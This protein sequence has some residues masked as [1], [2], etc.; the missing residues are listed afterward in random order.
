[1][2]HLPIGSWRSSHCRSKDGAANVLESLRIRNLGVIVDATLDMGRGLTVLTGETGAGKT[3]VLTAL[4]AVLGQKA[5]PGLIRFGVDRADVEA[6]WVV[7]AE[8]FAH[9][10]ERL[11]EIDAQLDVVA[12]GSVLI[13]NRSIAAQ[14]RSKTTVGGRSVASATL[15]EVIEPLVAVHGQADQWRLLRA[16]EQRTILDTFGGIDIAAYRQVYRTW[17]D[18]TS[19]LEQFDHD[20]QDA[21]AHVAVLRS[22]LAAIEAV[23]PEV[24]EDE[25]LDR[26]SNVLGHAVSI[27]QDADEI[28]LALDAQGEADHDAGEA[29]DRALRAADRI[30]AVDAGI[31]G[32][33]EL[34]SQSQVLIHEAAAALG[35]YV[36]EIDVD[37]GRL[38]EVE[39]RRR[40]LNDLKRRFGPSLADVLTWR[41][42]AQTTLTEIADPA[43][44]RAALQS[45]IEQ[46]ATAL[47]AQA[48][49]VTA[50]RSTA[51]EQLGSQVTGELQALAMAGNAL[52]VE[53]LPLPGG[54]GDFGAETVVF[55]L[56]TQAGGPPRPLAKGASGGELARVMLAIEV[57]V[58]GST[59][60]PTFVF[61]EVDAGVGGRA[62]IE[63]GRRLAALGRTAQVLVVTHLPQVAA[64][65]DTH[66]VVR[67]EADG[68]VN[69]SDVHAVTGDERVTEIARMLSGL[70][71][72][73]TGAD[74][75]RELLDLA[76]HERVA[77]EPRP[78][79][80]E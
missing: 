29:L 61:D 55:H 12:D 79:L 68:S 11:N 47:E 4:G 41:D 10:H 14:G 73:D 50:L 46:A 22:G 20:V 76:A 9:I 39:E 40:A 32:V 2:H 26:L 48:A 34:L 59:A 19:A 27:A 21:T 18:A 1:M 33:R 75:A 70:A 42:Q 16:D 63:V 45:A 53:L 64:F 74:H 13:V 24:G 67:K 28:R 60:V 5:D 36:A 58:A 66:I 62:A 51:A 3:M 80:I 6:T 43:A 57:V 23:Q 30:A 25:H 69:S 65:A 7:P 31:A 72:S 38:G 35:S 78:A 77:G 8:G 54:P 71:E 37:P 52:V 56:Q 49:L 15:R 17:R 44:H